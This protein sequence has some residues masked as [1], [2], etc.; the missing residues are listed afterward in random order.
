M[1]LLQVLTAGGIV[2]NPFPIPPAIASAELY[3]PNSQAWTTVAPMA[4]KR[5]QH[6]VKGLMVLARHGTLFLLG[7]RICM[8]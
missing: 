6:Q 8:G 4:V 1:W 5:V 2:Y 7:S 3:D